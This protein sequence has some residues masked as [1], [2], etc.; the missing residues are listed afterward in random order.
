MLSTYLD[1]YYERNLSVIQL[2][3]ES[4]SVAKVKAEA[5]E[6]SYLVQLCSSPHT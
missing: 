2:A 3:A 4:A 5:K 1:L 6:V